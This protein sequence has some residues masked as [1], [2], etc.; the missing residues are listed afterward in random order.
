MNWTPDPKR[1]VLLIHDMQEYF[2]DVYS[3]KESPKVELISNIKMI[4]ENVNNLVY[5]LFIQRGQTLEQRGLLQDFWG[6]G[7]PAGPDKR[8]LLMN[9]LLMRMIYSS[10]NGDIVHLKDKSIRNFK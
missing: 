7:I 9:L 2:L 5:Q 3:D 8:K 10:Q 1:A 6:D 4:R